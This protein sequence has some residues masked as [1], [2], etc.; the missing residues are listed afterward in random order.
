MVEGL[1]N[2]LG[3]QQRI[4]TGHECAG[5]IEHRLERTGNTQSDHWSAT[6]LRFDRNDAEILDTGKENDCRPLVRVSEVGPRHSANESDST[7][8]SC[9][10]VGLQMRSLGA[11]ADDGERH[12]CQRT[13]ID[14]KI[15]SFV[16]DQPSDN[17]GATTGP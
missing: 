13:G 14:R 9:L 4:R 17:H 10:G 8:R 11:V 15:H 6:A 12:A 3:E 16:R 7:R 2:C 5:M 1:S